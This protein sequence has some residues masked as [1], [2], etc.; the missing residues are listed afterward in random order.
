MKALI[1]N[2]EE[3]EDTIQWESWLLKRKYERSIEIPAYS[4][5]EKIQSQAEMYG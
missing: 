3:Y 5:L 4:D 1:R 2:E